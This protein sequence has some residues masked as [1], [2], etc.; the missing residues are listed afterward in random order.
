MKQ[1]FFYLLVSVL[2]L[3]S[4]NNY[5]QIFY[6]KDAEKIV[7]GSEITRL[8]EKNKSITF[9]QLRDN[10]SISTEN[11]NLWLKK[12]LKLSNSHDF[13]EIQ[14]KSDKKGFTHVKFQLQYKGIPVETAVYS[15]HSKGGRVYSANGEY[16]IGQ[17]IEVTP[18]IDEQKAFEIALKYVNA[19]QYKSVIDNK[20]DKGKLVILPVKNSYVLCYKFDIYALNPLSRQYIFVNAN[21][22]AVVKTFNRIQNSD[23]VGSAVTRYNGTVN[24][25]TDYTGSTYR[26]RE[27]IRGG[28]IE[29][30]DL[31]QST[32]YSSAVDFTDADNVWNTTTNYDNAA[33]DA[34]YATEATYDYYFNEFGRRSY[35]DADGK[36]LSYVHY[37]YNYVNAFWDGSC[38]TYGD[39]DGVEY[40]PLTP[41]EVVAHELTHGVTE[42][43]AGL[44]YESESGALNESFSDIFGVVVDF[45]KNPA[46]ANYQMG[47]AMSP[48]H[49]PFRSMSNPNEYGCP[50]TY[51]GDYWD[52]S[53]EVHTNSGVMNFW[54]YLLSEGGSDIN[55]NG[56]SY[57]VT[58]IGREKAA[59]IAYR[60]LT[61]YL[62]PS[63]G[64]EDARLYSIQSAIDLFGDCSAEV[65]AVTNAWHAVGVGT[66]FNNAIT[67]SFISSS[68]T[69]CDVPTTI[70][71][72]NRS[73][74]ASTYAWDFGDGNTST[75]EN[76][77]HTF[78]SAGSFNVRLIATGTATCN[79]SDTAFNTITVSDGSSPVAASCTPMS[80]NAGPGGIYQFTFNTISNTTNGSSDNYKDYTC[81]Y[82][83]TIQEGKEYNLAITI[84]N[85]KTEN[86]YIWLDLNNNGQFEGS[87][88]LFQKNKVSRSYSGEIIIPGGA[89][90]NVPLR[91]R[92]ASDL[93]D[94][95]MANACSNSN[96]GQIQDYTITV[97]QN[98]AKPEASFICNNKNAVSGDSVIF[99]DKSLNLPTSWLWSFPGGQPSSS[100]LQ[101]PV[102]TYNT[103][104]SYDVSLIAT[105]AQGADTITMPA[106]ISVTTPPPFALSANIADKNNGIVRLGWL[107]NASESISNDFSNNADEWTPIQG[108]WSV[109]GGAYAVSTGST[110]VSTSALNNPLSNYEYEAR[111]R[112]VSGEP[113]TMGLIFNGDPSTLNDDGTWAN[114]YMLLYQ[115]D[116]QWVF[117]KIENSIWT[118]IK[119]WGISSDIA[120]EIGIWNT[121]KVVYANGYIDIL[122]NGINQGS[123]FDNTFTNG[124]VGLLMYDPSVGQAEFDYFTLLPISST[125]NFGLNKNNTNQ[126]KYQDGSG[127]YFSKT[128]SKQIGSVK[129]HIPTFGNKYSFVP[130]T[131]AFQ[132]FIIYRNDNQIDTTSNTSYNDT[133]PTYGTYEYKVTALYDEGES[134]PAGPASV[135]WTEANAGDDCSNAQDLAKLTSPYSGTTEG[136]K[137][138]FSF[139]GNSPDRIFYIDLLPGDSLTIGQIDNDYD[140]RHSLRYGG[141]CPGNTEIICIDDPDIQ[142]HSYANTTTEIQRIYWIQQGYSSDYGNFEL[143]WYVSHVSCPKPTTLNADNI[144]LTSVDLTW[145]PGMDENLWDVEWGLTG[146][147]LQEI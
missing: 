136:Y 135:T 99:T 34:H 59:Q 119:S 12:A 48:T 132:N 45:Y 141:S 60:N 52:P 11:Q 76:P 29:T 147:A 51:Q 70:Y 101:N 69:G 105:N 77:S 90:Y 75:D 120:Q 82:T 8:N 117:Y 49:T 64:Y 56:D 134:T 42:Y 93:S 4:P 74:K 46:T 73:V 19:K 84:G 21:T 96:Y 81:T 129:P 61:V 142:I 137:I 44:I 9:I 103:P 67:A 33:Y 1:K 122:F 123:F 145:T 89:Q 62:T 109:S 107:K 87:E 95:I 83:T 100:T 133:L 143:S 13:K 35:N 71:F 53:E 32:D 116:G 22:G 54:F 124:Q 10:A 98:I 108:N 106:Y 79:S 144:T 5:G 14:K 20:R 102:I 36:L 65:V 97:T 72:Y 55:D 127:L 88:L 58:G 30:Y 80:L 138:D 110:L 125:Y 38:M 26:L 28:G 92:V 126:I 3:I 115:C 17:S 68:T 112:K 31:N 40:Y 94:S 37:D 111:M 24:I 6:K 86:I 139:C 140:S 50:D 27:T 41:I 113:Y 121:I 57:S 78:A 114:C 131:R 128:S 146:F 2:F 91:L 16:T 63:S 23:T 47:D 104:G 7:S 85:A 25:T 18:Q 118:T 130:S 66:S 15:V 43:S 39:G